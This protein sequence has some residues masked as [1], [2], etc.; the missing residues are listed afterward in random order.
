MQIDLSRFRDAFFQE[1]EEHLAAME[2]GLLALESAPGEP[3]LLNSIFRGAHSI[4]GASGTF[5]FEDIKRF[6]HALETLLDGMRAG[7]LAAT[8]DRIGVLLRSLD[9]LRAQVA[10]A[11]DG[12][13]APEE[14]AVLLA[15]LSAATEDSPAAGAVYRVR[16]LPGPETFQQGMDPVL[17][18]RELAQRGEILAIEPELDRLPALSALD[19]EI[20][21]LG[22]TVR[23]ASGRPVEEIRDAF[24]FVEDTSV[25]EIAR[26]TDAA[27]SAPA[28]RAAV[29][30]AAFTTNETSMRVATAKVDRLVD[31]V[32]ELVI[33]ESMAAQILGSFQMSQL[34]RLQEAFSQ[35]ERYTRELQERV[36]S[37]RMRPIGAVFSRFPRM[38]HD[39]GEAI[40]KQVSLETVGE[41]TELDKGVVEQ[42]AD[43][44]THLIRNA[45][46][47]GIETAAERRRLGKPEQGLIRLAA[48]HQGG[49]V[50]V[51]VSDDGR[52][53]DA[54]AIRAK[55]VERGLISAD[56][57]MTDRDMQ[58]LIFEPGFSTAAQ[59]SDLSG[60]GV[61]MDVVKRQVEALN[62][63]V[64]LWSEPGKGARIR[65]KLPLTLAILDGLLLKVGSQTYVLPL[66]SILE[67]IQPKAGDTRLLPNGTEVVMARGE[68]E[69]L[70][71]LDRIFGVEGAVSDPSRGLVVLVENQGRRLALLVDEIVGQQQVV[72]KSLETHFRKVDGLLG[73][74]ILGDGHPALILDVGGLAQSVRGSRTE[75][76]LAA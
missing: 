25:V 28:P 56:A 17:V 65:I 46:D 41:E 42:M 54:A 67:S 1:A 4:K 5:G 70:V 19:P 29:R 9:V 52:G 13:G 68:A 51:E 62:G 40:G 10:A 14:P 22:W 30:T 47:H 55:A 71:R 33:A 61:G 2:A 23:L 34:G 69:P 64:D 58:A 57:Q 66:I 38:V 31:L 16:F 18:L 7:R 26:E 20:C 72:I 53:L 11:R 15:E 39:L 24:S 74:T 48:S 35:M 63:T 44:L 36:M 3:E 8:R 27:K 59:V 49:N 76:T 21:Y 50:I 60:R 6:T 43:P 37:V 45:V 73:A 75:G 32:G 12:S